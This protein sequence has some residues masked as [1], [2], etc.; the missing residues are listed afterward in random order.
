[1]RFISDLGRLAESVRDASAG[2]PGN[3]S[4]PILAGMHIEAARDITLTSFDGNV[5]FTAKYEKCAADG[6]WF[7]DILETGTIVVPGRLFADIIRNLPGDTIEFHDQ[8][9][10]AYVHAGNVKFMLPAQDPGLYPGGL[11]PAPPRGEIEG[12]ALADAIAKVGPSVSRVP[13]SPA[14]TCILAEPD[15]DC[16]ALVASDRSRMACVR[17]PWT[18]QGDVAPVLIPG[19]AAEK[20][21]RAL[22]GRVTLGWDSKRFSMSCE[23]LE[24]ISRGIAGEHLKWREM[25]PEGDGGITVDAPALEAAIRQVSL[26]LAR[27]DPVQLSFTGNDL[28]VTGTSDHGECVSYLEVKN[29]GMQKTI[30]VKLGLGIILDGLAGCGEEAVIGFAGPGKPVKL[31]SEGFRYL[32]APRR[33]Q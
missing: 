18:P 17:V 24:V 6:G 21:G 7:A 20:F 32:M 28:E 26:V 22:K 10:K 13:S 33:I 15:G 23:G 3:P 8:D 19:W 25:L 12:S 1:M 29:P 4:S 27:T 16:L 14:F 5:M 2:L 30:T 9:G 11:A 31:Y